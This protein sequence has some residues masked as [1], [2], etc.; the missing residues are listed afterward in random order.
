MWLLK[1]STSE[2]QVCVVLG[3]WITSIAKNA[4]NKTLRYLLNIPK[5]LAEFT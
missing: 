5:I 4:V 3:V 2:L 1:N